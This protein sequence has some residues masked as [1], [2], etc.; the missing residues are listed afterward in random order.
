MAVDIEVKYFNSILLKK[1]VN[2]NSSK[3]DWISLPW[4]PP[5][6]PQFPLNANTSSDTY[7]WY[8]EESRIRGGYNNVELDL[9]VR[10]YVSEEERQFSISESDLIYSGA[11][12][13]RT[14]TN[15]TNVFSVGDDITKS[16]DPRYGSIQRLYAEDSNLL[17]LQENKV[18]LALIDKSAIYSATGEPITTSSNKVFGEVQPYTGEYGIGRHPE[19]FAV[20]GYRKYFADVPNSSVMRLSR[21]GFTEISKNGMDDFFRSE[22][23]NISHENKRHIIDVN[24]N[25]VIGVPISTIDVSGDDIDSIEYGMKIEGIIG[26]GEIYV[27]DIQ[28]IS[29]GL[30]LELSNTITITESTQPD[31]IQLVKFVKDKVVGGYDNNTDQYIISIQ[32]IRPTRLSTNNQSV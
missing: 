6:Y 32:N 23:R 24:W 17:I 7:N 31:L 22:F 5:F 9:G 14:S 30:R 25:K 19:S 28:E 13:S 4:N 21:N 29:G 16:I 20:K 12:N 2:G 3:S 8:V 1:V 10:A 11:Y 15:K 18:S 27:N 26:S